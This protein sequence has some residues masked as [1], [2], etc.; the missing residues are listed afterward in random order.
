MHSVAPLI[1]VPATSPAYTPKPLEPCSPSA[2]ISS[3]RTSA[4]SSVFPQAAQEPLPTLKRLLL[5][6]T[7]PTQATYSDAQ[8][9]HPDT[10][11]AQYPSPALGSEEAPSS[12]DKNSSGKRLKPLRSFFGGFIERV[13]TATQR[14]AAATSH[15]DHP[16]RF[17]QGT[18]SFGDS[19][20]PF[21]QLTRPDHGLNQ[22]FATSY[23]A[24]DRMSTAENERARRT[25]RA[26]NSTAPIGRGE[27]NYLNDTNPFHNT[28]LDLLGDDTGSSAQAEFP[29]YVP[30]ATPFDINTALLLYTQAADS[31]IRLGFSGSVL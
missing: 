12:S 8:C 7:P 5:T 10:D 26:R 30:P 23:H 21:D 11:T 19:C 25:R 6:V 16:T 18:N 13:R 20:S 2:I 4:S 29:P 1:L 14:E 3:P 22:V 17:Q 27:N 31:G 24:E 15:S 9:A 28:S